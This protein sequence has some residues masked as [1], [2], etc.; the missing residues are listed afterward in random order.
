KVLVA[1]GTVVVLIALFLPAVRNARPAADRNTCANQLHQIAIAINNYVD[2]HHALPPL[3]TS[4]ASG[5]PLHSWRTLILPYLEERTLFDSI[6]LTKPWNDPAN[7]E[8]CNTGLPAYQC[9]A[10]DLRDNR[11]TYLAVVTP[12][13]LLQP[14][15]PKKLSAITDGQK[16]LMVIEV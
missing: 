2:A 4:D 1:L 13:S 15:E 8:A 10:S 14:G 3:Y 16:T 5:K 11:T 6:D 12:N 7:S 9:P